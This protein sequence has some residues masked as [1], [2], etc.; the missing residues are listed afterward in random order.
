MIKIP[1]FNTIF[2]ATT[3]END[4]AI[5]VFLFPMSVALGKNDFIEKVEYPETKT[6]K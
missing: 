4:T 6:S 1:D 3:F 5:N 2:C